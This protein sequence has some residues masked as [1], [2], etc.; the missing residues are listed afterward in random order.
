MSKKW[1]ETSSD[2]ACRE[3]ELDR[4]FDDCIASH[5]RPEDLPEEA[6][7]EL[8]VWLNTNAKDISKIFA[9][10][11]VAEIVYQDWKTGEPL[12]VTNKYGDEVEFTRS[13]Y[14]IEPPI[15]PGEDKPRKYA[16]KPG[17]I[18]ELYWDRSIDWHAIMYEPSKRLII[19]E[20]EFKAQALCRAGYPA[21]GLGGVWNWL[22]DGTPITQM[23]DPNWI[24]RKVITAFD[25]DIMH[26]GKD[27]IL[28]AENR[29]VALLSGWGA[30]VRRNRFDDAPDGSIV[31]ADDYLLTHTNDEFDALLKT[32]TTDSAPDPEEVYDLAATEFEPR[33]YVW[34]NMVPAYQVTGLYGEPGVGKSHLALALALAVTQG[35]DFLG[36]TT[37]K[38]PVL[39]VF[40][41][42][43]SQEVGERSAPIIKHLGKCKKKHKRF[44]TWTASS[45]IVPALA[46]IEDT[47]KIEHLA[48]YQTLR[49]WLERIGEPCF[50][51]LDSLAD[52]FHLNEAARLAANAALKIVLQSLCRE[53]DATVIIL[54]HPSKASLVD[55]SFYSGSTAWI[56]ATRTQLILKF[57]EV[58]KEQQRTSLVDGVEPTKG[59]Q[60]RELIVGKSNLGNKGTKI[61]V[62]LEDGILVKSIPLNMQSKG[63]LS[64][65]IL[66]EVL[67]LVD[68]GCRI[69]KTN[70]G[71]R[72]TYEKALKAKVFSPKHLAQFMKE[73]TGSNVSWRKVM[74]V[75]SILEDQQR[76]R[77]I[78]GDTDARPKILATFEAGA[79]A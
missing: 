72:K 26:P 46:A 31:G 44:H 69:L 59:S 20:G 25:S 34:E 76:L 77:Y 19:V 75:L 38:M 73:E 54:G 16:Q 64:M 7:E 53:F 47:G 51:I 24:G 61:N 40:S 4:L 33:C 60:V 21:I 43:D 32:A 65:S 2:Q 13:R 68:D 27:G 28:Q 30:D 58:K 17:T 22:K 12:I 1:G 5:F 62:T 36:F 41:E 6:G 56:A 57:P 79:K 29:L 3:A 67:D 14:L 48:F 70:N 78:E 50:V 10:R 23:G 49:T 39:A 74:E 66:N 63:Q 52:M 42:D 8:D 37:T 35:K 55:G 9:E 11:P 45:D 71:G 15:I 18:P